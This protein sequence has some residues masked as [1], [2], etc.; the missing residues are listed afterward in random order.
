[1]AIIDTSKGVRPV[2]EELAELKNAK[3]LYSD[4][5]PLFPCWSYENNEQMNRIKNGITS[6]GVTIKYEGAGV[7]SINGTLSESWTGQRVQDITLSTPIPAAIL[8]PEYYRETDNY[9]QY[10]VDA[11]IDCR[12]TDNLHNVF[13]GYTLFVQV[14]DTNG[15]IHNLSTTALTYG[16]GLSRLA[17]LISIRKSEISTPDMLLF[18]ESTILGFRFVWQGVNIPQGTEFNAK[19]FLNIYSTRQYLTHSIFAR[20]TLIE[21]SN[22]I[23]HANNANLLNMLYTLSYPRLQIEKTLPVSITSAPITNLYTLTPE[24]E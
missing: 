24:G 1:M 13:I 23:E 10:V 11:L 8:E 17:S 7:F 22:I 3:N 16:G 12:A 9:F 2:V 21:T 18:E 5:A 20:D 15:V 14:P 4:K 6:R 19:H